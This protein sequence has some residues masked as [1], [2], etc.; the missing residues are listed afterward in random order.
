MR[1]P[2]YK[3]HTNA[4]DERLIQ[5]L[6]THDVKTG[7]TSTYQSI[8]NN[9][10]GTSPWGAERTWAAWRSRYAHHKAD[11]DRR[12]K[13][14]RQKHGITIGGDDSG[15]TQTSTAGGSSNL[16]GS[17][18]TYRN[19]GGNSTMSPMHTPSATPTPPVIYAQPQGPN[20]YTH[21]YYGYSPTTP[22]YPPQPIT[23]Y[24]APSAALSPSK[25]S[26]LTLIAERVISTNK[27]SPS[28]S[29]QTSSALTP[30]KSVPIQRREQM[31]SGHQPLTVYVSS[32]GSGLGN[33]AASSRTENVEEEVDSKPTSASA[34]SALP[35]RMARK[36]HRASGSGPGH[37]SSVLSS[38]PATPSTGKDELDLTTP[39]KKMKTSE[40]HHSL[41]EP[42]FDGSSIF[43]D[44]Q[45][46]SPTGT[47]APQMTDRGTI[48]GSFKFG[49][50]APAP[51]PDS[52]Y[53]HSTST[54]AVI[55][56]VPG[57]APDDFPYTPSISTNVV[58]NKVVPGRGA[59]DHLY[60]PS[61]S[62][63]A[64]SKVV[65]DQ[66]A[67]GFSTSEPATDL[68]DPGYGGS[69][70]DLEYPD[71]GDDYSLYNGGQPVVNSAPPN[72]TYTEPQDEFEAVFNTGT[73]PKLASRGAEPEAPLGKADTMYTECYDEE[74]DDEEPTSV[75]LAGIPGGVGWGG[76]GHLV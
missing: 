31:S 1:D 32:N 17:S 71:E 42:S 48:N 39:T 50:T 63:N 76:L 28:I 52:S 59:S 19:S 51:T 15:R 53:S 34:A 44:S 72:Q 5:F 74:D 27:N 55:K 36:R 4:D 11:F 35:A 40:E 46:A 62:Y 64:A 68:P 12:I 37:D 56:V 47:P 2:R 65:Y 29:A 38:T 41:R 25:N 67:S 54:K 61:E 24:A 13:Q 75:S 60:S 22:Y 18:S 26:N 66:N 20:P 30:T 49:M 43:A 10:D 58:N 8:V 9:E 69:V 23:A 7:S 45:V 3:P 57:R 16:V 14:Y 33:A 21:S 73:S 70:S 6:A